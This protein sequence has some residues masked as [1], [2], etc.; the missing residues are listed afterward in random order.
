MLF[1]NICK[2]FPYVLYNIKN[3]LVISH[4]EGY[5]FSLIVTYSMS[6]ASYVLVLGDRPFPYLLFCQILLFSLYLRKYVNNLVIHPQK[7]YV[8]KIYS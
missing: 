3:L 6:S 8:C 2:L 4:L 5:L 1:R 7:K